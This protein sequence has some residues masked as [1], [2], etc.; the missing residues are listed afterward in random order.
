VVLGIASQGCLVGSWFSSCL[1][2]MHRV[3]S[4]SP[5]AHDDQSVVIML[6]YTSC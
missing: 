6:H 1:W 2:F 3:K 5:A 4:G